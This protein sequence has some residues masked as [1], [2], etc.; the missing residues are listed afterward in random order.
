M[1]NTD[2]K[3]NTGNKMNTQTNV[4][5]KPRTASPKSKGTGWKVAIMVASLAG[6]IGG[7]GALAVSQGEN[8]AA[9]SSQPVAQPV[10]VPAVNPN[11]NPGT[12]SPSTTNPGTTTTGRGSNRQ[13][14]GLRQVSP[15]QGFPNVI[16]RS[17]SSR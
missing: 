6:M 7:W 14:P 4:Q 11:F 13:Q 9:A 12:T 16:T 15:S 8:V 10:S 5:P 1:I 2:S 3:L 17:R